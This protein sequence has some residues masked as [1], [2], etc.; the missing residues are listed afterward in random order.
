MLADARER[1][2]RPPAVVDRLEHGNVLI[3]DKGIRGPTLTHIPRL[4]HLRVADVRGA[5]RPIR[6]LDRPG[7]AIDHVSKPVV[8]HAR[9]RG[10]DASEPKTVRRGL[11]VRRRDE[12]V[13]KPVPVGP[14]LLADRLLVDVEHPLLVEDLHGDRPPSVRDHHGPRGH[15]IGNPVIEAGRAS[16]TAEQIAVP[17]PVPVAIDVRVARVV[18][19]IPLQIDVGLLERELPRPGKTAR[20]VAVGRITARRASVHR[21]GEVGDR[22]SRSEGGR[23]PVPVGA[24]K[25][26]CRSGRRARRQ[27]AQAPGSSGRRRRRRAG[28]GRPGRHRR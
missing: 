9:G 26:P 13:R 5:H 17:P 6:P 15:R 23:G 18:V 11:V 14:H 22:G 20:V 16:A 28:G 2:D 12:D 19:S 27:G 3:V 1:R 25:A 8:I 7:A 4:E 21:R 10:G 24:R